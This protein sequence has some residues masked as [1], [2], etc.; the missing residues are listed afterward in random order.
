MARAYVEEAERR[1]R[2]AEM[3]LREKAYAYSIRQC[4]EAVELLLK[5]SLRLIG[6]EPPKWH[7]VGPILLEFSERFPD[8]F[9]EK[10]PELAAISRWLRREREPSMYG[11]E[12]LGLPPTKL[13]AEPYAL[14]AVEGART[15]YT[16]V[17]RLLDSYLSSW[18][19]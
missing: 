19:Q 2:I 16:Y 7:D 8:W 3:M 14:K 17:K 4:Q 9:R 11:D 5:A 18:Q 6:I 12:E 1:I 10:I 15:V 13:Y